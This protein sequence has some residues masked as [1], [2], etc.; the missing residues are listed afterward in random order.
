MKIIKY[1]DIEPVEFNNEIAMGIKACVLIGK[2]DGAQNFC[3]RIF[4]I[5]ENGY[6]PRHTHDWEHEMFVHSGEGKVLSGSEWKP[7]SSGT[8]IFIPGNVEHQVKNSGTEP[9][10]LLCMIPSGAPEL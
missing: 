8:A 4:T 6:T 9:L 3:M 5:S 10:I 1:T 7:V 2:N